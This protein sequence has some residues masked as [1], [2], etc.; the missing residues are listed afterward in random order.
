MSRPLRL[1]Y[2]GAWYRVMNRGRNREVTI[3]VLLNC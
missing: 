1:L 3:S 2:P